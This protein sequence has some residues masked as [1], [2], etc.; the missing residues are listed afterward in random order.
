[1]KNKVQLM[2][3]LGQNPEIRY[4]SAGVAVCNFSVATNERW[5]DAQGETQEH[6]EWHRIVVWGKL[7]ETCAEHLKKGRLVDIEGKLRTRKWTNAE[8]QNRYS[9]EIRASHVTFLPS[10]SNQS[11]GERQVD[12][13]QV[14]DA[15]LS[16]E[17]EE[18][19]NRADSEETPF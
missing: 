19:F 16:R 3:N 18:L 5:K 7:A 12:E 17:A 6:T 9:T 14:P 15:A 8:G 2:G 10:R 13:S 4:T 11:Q 1:M